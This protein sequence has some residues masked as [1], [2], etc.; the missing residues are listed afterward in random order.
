[1]HTYWKG[2]LKVL[3]NERSEYLLLDL[4]TNKPKPYHKTFYNRS[5]KDKSRRYCKERLFRNSRFLF[6][7]EI[8]D[9]S[10]ESKRVDILQFHV[11]WLGYDEIHNSWEPWKNLRDLAVL[12][13]YLRANNLGGI[14][15]RT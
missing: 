6:V 11:K 10:G 13:E 5:S 7:K 9:F 3:I 8:L 14:T 12:H 2:P 15:T 4:F 1:M